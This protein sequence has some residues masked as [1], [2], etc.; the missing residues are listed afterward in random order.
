MHK[1]IRTLALATT[2]AATMTTPLHAQEPVSHGVEIDQ[3]T[4]NTIAQILG[5]IDRTAVCNAVENSPERFKEVL[6]PMV[7]SRLARMAINAL[8]RTDFEAYCGTQDG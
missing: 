5:D 2:L 8:S 6:G 1:Q 7:D 4:L 3:P